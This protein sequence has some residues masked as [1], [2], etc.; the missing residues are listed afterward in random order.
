MKTE[1][2]KNQGFTLL[3]MLLVL[4]IVSSILGMVLNLS[5]ARM[6]QFRREKTAM[7]MQAVMTAASAYFVAYNAWPNIAG[8]QS[9]GY[10]PPGTIASAWGNAITLSG[11]GQ[12]ATVSTTL[13]GT[14]ATANAGVVA[15]M[16][17]MAKNVSGAITAYLTIPGQNLNNAMAVNYGAVYYSGSCVP[18]PNCPSGM[19]ASLMV[20]PV[21]VTG[22]QGSPG[23]CTSSQDPNSCSSMSVSPLTS[24]RAFYTGSGSSGASPPDCEITGNPNA[25]ACVFPGGATETNQAANYWRVCLEVVT[26]T[27]LAYPS[28]SDTYAYNEGKLMG[29][30]LAVT[31]CMPSGG[32]TPS[33]S[34]ATNF[35]PNAGW[36]K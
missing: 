29:N 15:G 4:V 21:A 6:D 2:S 16:L 22:I 5:T 20:M 28:A 33:G 10:I 26:S 14:A 24:F 36:A 17:P 9:A 18:Q 11:S 32:D 25:V 34:D 3:E 8:L 30:I 23:G 19:T 7:Q 12:T 13:T 31:R 27:G 35:T 1:L